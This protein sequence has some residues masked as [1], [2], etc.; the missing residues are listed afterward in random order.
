MIWKIVNLNFVLKN[1]ILFLNDKTINNPIIIIKI[2]KME[3]LYVFD[4]N[5]SR[6]LFWM[7]LKKGTI[8]SETVNLSDNS[9]EFV[10]NLTGSSIAVY[11]T[12]TMI[13]K[14]SNGIIFSMF[15][16]CIF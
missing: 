3:K 6:L 12:E 15:I 7:D 10:S 16:I 5:S 4:K 14:N 1:S 13:E 8:L 9:S 2:F 11:N